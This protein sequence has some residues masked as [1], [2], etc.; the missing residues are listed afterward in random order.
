MN[1]LQNLK[2][3]QRVQQ[4]LYQ[5]VVRELLQWYLIFVLMLFV[6]LTLNPFILNKDQNSFPV[7]C[8]QNCYPKSIFY[9]KLYL[10]WGC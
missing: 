7:F 4:I 5:Q 1:E 9:P 10:Y 8:F 3:V 2:K 6:C